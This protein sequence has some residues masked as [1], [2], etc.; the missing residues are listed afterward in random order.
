MVEH[1]PTCYCYEDNPYVCEQ[2]EKS[3][4]TLM[5]VGTVQDFDNSGEV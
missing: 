4:K 1:N 5:L 3:D 2:C